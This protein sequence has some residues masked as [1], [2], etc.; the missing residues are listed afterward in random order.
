ML[1][2]CR[3]LALLYTGNVTDSL[4]RLRYTMYMYATATSSNLPRPERL[5]PTESAARYHL[6]RVHL[7]V[8]HWKLLSTATLN[9]SEWGWK[10]HEGKY[11]PVL[12]DMDIAHPDVLKVACCKCSAESKR[13][14]G[15]RVCLCVKYG[16]SCV[17]A[18]KNCNGVACGNVQE[19]DVGDLVESEDAE[20]ALL[21]NAVEEIV[22]DEDI[23]YYMPWSI[24]EEVM[25]SM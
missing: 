22:D 14:C 16:L 17:T 7:Q 2:G 6:Y 13:P 5:P 8:V 10:M 9:P 3:M 20:I 24:E 18:C 1:A 23:D 21:D 19:I 15:T 12:T 25:T 4:N 11:N